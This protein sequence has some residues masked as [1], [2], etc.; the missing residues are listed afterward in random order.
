LTIDDLVSRV[1]SVRGES[2]TRLIA[3][4]GRGG[5]GKTRLATELSTRL[6]NAF[7]IH[8]DDFA[9]PHLPS[10]DWQRFQRD[11]LVALLD[12][13]PAVFQRY[14]WDA[15][16]LAEAIDVPTGGFVIVEGISSSRLEL[17]PV[18]DFVV[19]VECPR[20]LRLNR[21]IERDGERLR[22]KWERVWMPEEDQYVM[23]Q[24]PVS[25]ADAVVDGSDLNFY[26]G[27]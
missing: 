15:D 6:P 24:D 27:S 17:G 16:R 18:W 26:T 14:D 25:R 1:G 10:W 13:R 9:S 2:R 4:D 7:V 21:G 3:I 20:D 5:A 23:S 11:V 19:W 8:T 12:D 22:W